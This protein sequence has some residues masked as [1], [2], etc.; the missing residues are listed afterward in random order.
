[1]FKFESHRSNVLGVKGAVASNHSLATHNGLCVLEGGGN[2]ADCAIAMAATLAVVEPMSSGLGGDTFCLFY[3][4]RSRQ[5]KAVNGSGRS[6]S[7]VTL[8]LVTSNGFST[9]NPI[10]STHGLAVNV[11]GAPA[12]LVD[13]LQDFGSGK[14]SLKQLLSP[15]IAFAENGFPVYEWCGHGWA[16]SEAK[17]RKSRFGNELLLNDRTPRIGE[18]MNI[19]TM[20]TTLK[21]LAQ[22]GKDGFYKGRVAE[23]IVSEVSYSGGVLTLE[24]L[25]SHQTS[26][27]EPIST[28][29]QDVRLWEAPPNGLGINALL[30]LNILE[31]FDMKAL[32]RNSVDYLHVLT[33]AFKLSFADTLRVVADPASAHVPV[34][35]LLSKDYAASRRKLIDMS[36]SLDAY[37]PGN[38]GNIGTDTTYAAAID[39]EGCACSF[40]TSVYEGFGSGIVPEG[41]GFA[42]NNRGLN[43]SLERNQPNAIGPNKRSLHTIIPAMLTSSGSSSS[44]SSDT[45]LAAMGIVGGF[46]QSQA[47]VQVMLNLRVFGLSPQEALDRPRLFVNVPNNM[48]GISPRIGPVQVEEG[49]H[50][51]VVA[52]L[53]AKGHVVEGPFSDSDRTRFGRGCLITRGDWWRNDQ[54][55]IGGEDDG[56]VMWA[57]ADPRGDG[58]AL[59]FV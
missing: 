44:N 37:V 5:V 49:I 36:K 45:L 25:A 9:S 21:M 16:N 6:G 35:V 20:A 33:E 48:G 14:F 31:G 54:Q 47:H 59:A 10:P 27:V 7:R 13:I 32:G 23:A 51:D 12:A 58:N 22:D 19:P 55:P 28:S 18:I 38:M 15:A 11:P 17:L 1:M 56:H 53:R 40:I 4:S 50:P 8:D 52:G 43:F 46:M 29:F 30:A 41:C 26:R 2:A 42:L 34:D 39:S 24:D 3:D 57:A